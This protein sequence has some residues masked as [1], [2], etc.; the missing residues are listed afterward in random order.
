MVS[1]ID[2]VL[3]F[4][5]VL[6]CV[7]YMRRDKTFFHHIAD[8]WISTS[9]Q[10]KEVYRP[11][12]RTGSR[13][14]KVC[15]VIALRWRGTII[16]PLVALMALLREGDRKNSCFICSGTCLWSPFHSDRIQIHLPRVG[17]ITIVYQIRG[18]FNKKTLQ[19]RALWEH[20]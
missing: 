5:K 12:S 1:S 2:F 15:V 16:S 4:F 13:L 18:G 9:N 11:R 19:R 7:M 20:R 6:A 17:P 3:K 8:C 10:R 14:R